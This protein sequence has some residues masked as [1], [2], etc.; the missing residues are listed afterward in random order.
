MPIVQEAGWTRRPVCK[1]AKN[2]PSH[3]D[4]IPGPSSPQRVAIMSSMSL[5]AIVIMSF[6]NI[7]LFNLVT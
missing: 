5:S 2:L 3:L 6:R 4:S 1:G 7:R